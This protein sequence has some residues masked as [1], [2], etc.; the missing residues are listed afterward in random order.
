VSSLTVLGLEA[1]EKFKILRAFE[2]L[3]YCD[4]IRPAF[5]PSLYG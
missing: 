3:H 5:S 2:R 4:G 1:A